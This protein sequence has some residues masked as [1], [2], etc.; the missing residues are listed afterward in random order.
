MTSTPRFFKPQS[1]FNRFEWHSYALLGIDNTEIV[2]VNAVFRQFTDRQVLRFNIH[3]QQWTRTALTFNG[4]PR[5]SLPA[6]FQEDQHVIGVRVAEDIILEIF[7]A[8]RCM[9]SNVHVHSSPLDTTTWCK[10]WLHPLASGTVIGIMGGLL[11]K[12]TSCCY[13]FE[14]E[15]GNAT[16]KRKL[17]LGPHPFWSPLC[18]YHVHTHSVW[19]LCH[20]GSEMICQ[21]I[22][23]QNWSTQTIHALDD[24]V[25]EFEPRATVLV[26]SGEYMI[27]FPRQNHSAR[28]LV[29]VWNLWTNTVGHSQISL[30][31]LWE[32]ENDEI[33]G[34]V[35]ATVVGN[36]AEELQQS[37]DY[38]QY[39]YHSDPRMSKVTEIP[40]YL[41]QEIDL[42]WSDEWIHLILE[43]GSHYKI[44]ADVILTQIVWM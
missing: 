23:L 14:I 40:E 39:Q 10:M 11:G 44:S 31:P 1:P 34:R 12:G 24:K 7:N 21:Q 15:D 27:S 3:Q 17:N 8:N 9:V 35:C 30:V 43:S 42:W 38:I 6:I 26:R 19:I 29:S 41:V 25:L 4:N 22:S 20:T 36:A 16:I 2:A 37:I 13:E 5:Y 32:R 28:Q 33:G 18:Q